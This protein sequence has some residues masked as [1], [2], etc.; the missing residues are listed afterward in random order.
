[1]DSVWKNDRGGGGSCGIL[2]LIADIFGARRGQIAL[3]CDAPRVL[4]A[5]AA[6]ASRH[7]AMD[8]ASSVVDNPGGTASP[9]YVHCFPLHS[10]A[11]LFL[12]AMHMLMIG[13]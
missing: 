9:S 1:M 7:P 12:E 8:P 3:S 13:L 6:G 2:Q 11:K 4:I 5:H 10:K